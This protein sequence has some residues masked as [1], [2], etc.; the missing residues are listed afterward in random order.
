LNNTASG[1][2]NLAI[3]KFVVLMIDHHSCGGSDPLSGLIESQTFS[4][5]HGPH[6][7]YMNPVSKKLELIDAVQS[8][9][10]KRLVSDVIPSKP[11]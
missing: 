7:I 1:D 2:F 5:P 4:S 3:E 11:T 9:R 8:A 6:V 10:L